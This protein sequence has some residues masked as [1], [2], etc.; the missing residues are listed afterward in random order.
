MRLEQLQILEEMGV[1]YEKTIDRFVN[2]DDFYLKLLFQVRQ[3]NNL[4]LLAHGIKVEEKEESFSS[5]HTLKGLYGNMG[6]SYC[7]EKAVVVTDLL[8]DENPDWLQIKE[9]FE[10][11]KQTHEDFLK[12]LERLEQV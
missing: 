11:L 3:D 1:D 12:Q 7:Y 2:K 10:G 8:R 4:E 9:S 5:A 6:L